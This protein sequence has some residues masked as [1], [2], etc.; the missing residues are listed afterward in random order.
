MRASED[1]RDRKD[2]ARFDRA[3][4]IATTAVLWLA[5]GV[6]A[7]YGLF[8]S[9][10]WMLRRQVTLVGV[11]LEV[12]AG[13][14]GT[15][16]VVGMP[17]AQVL[18]DGVSAGHFALLMA[19]QVLSLAAMVWGAVLVTRL[20]RDMGRGEPF[21]RINV[22]RL[23]VMALLLVVVP[24]VADFVTAVATAKIL[25]ARDVRAFAFEFSFG[26]MVGGLLLAAI[27]QAFA[28]GTKLRAD[29]DGLV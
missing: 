28:N 7:A 1:R 22:W 5:V 29:V 8:I 11:P 24:I 21:T 19:P 3:D 9:L 4:K 2:W 17:D 15:G 20:L 12:D 27:A 16:R 23:R 13:A 6:S 25:M 26:W 18:V 10:D 14:A